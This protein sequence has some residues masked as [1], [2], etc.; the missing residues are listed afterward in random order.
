VYI[1]VLEI[2]NPS[3]MDREYSVN[4]L[5]EHAGISIA[6][7]ENPRSEKRAADKQLAAWRLLLSV[8]IKPFDYH[9]IQRPKMAQILE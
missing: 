2:R 8:N 4:Q 9:M 7:I 3:K 5:V 1:G 6:I